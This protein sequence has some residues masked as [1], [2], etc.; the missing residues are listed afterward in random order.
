MSTLTTTTTETN[1]DGL[2]KLVF[3][4]GPCR[5]K[6]LLIEQDRI[7]FGRDDEN[8]VAI[9]HDI[10]SSRH[11]ILSRQLPAGSDS[12]ADARP[13]FRLR[14]LESKNGTFVNGERVEESVELVDG[15]VIWLCRNG[16]EVEFTFGAPELPSLIATST[17]T[18]HRTGSIGSAVRELLPRRKDRRLVSAS[19]VREFV[20][21]TLEESSRRQRRT[22]VIVG[23]VVASVL[24]FGFVLLAALLIGVGAGGGGGSAPATASI[25]L[26][27]PS[28]RPNMHIE[29]DVH[30]IFSSLFHS[31]REDGIGEIRVQNRGKETVADLHLWVDLTGK[32]KRL[33]AEAMRFDLPALS[34]SQEWKA[35]LRPVLTGETVTDRSLDATIVA[36]LEVAGDEIVSVDR[37]VMIHDYHAFS[38]E[39]PERVT[40]FVDSN[41]AAV[42][43]FADAAWAHQPESPGRG[44]P[45]VNVTR[46]VT[47]LTALASQ[48][49]SYKPDAETPVSVSKEWKARDRVN[50]PGETLLHG[51]G[52]CDDL[53]VLCC[54]LL[55]TAGVPSAVVVGE[56]HVLLMLDTGLPAPGESSEEGGRAA[57]FSRHSFVEHAGRIWLPIEATEL[58]RRDGTFS[59]AWGAAWSRIE[60]IDAGRMSVVEVREGWKKYKPLHPAPSDDVL[61]QIRDPS[62][63]RLSGLEKRIEAALETVRGHGR[64]NL[65]RGLQALEDEYEGA[66]LAQARAYL[67]ADG[68]LYR[69][70]VEVLE[71]E[72]FG[73]DVPRRAEDVRVQAQ[74][75]WK[76]EVPFDS[77]V[78]LGDLSLD[79]TLASSDNVELDRAVAFLDI[80]I[81]GFPDDLPEKAEM[82][83]RLGLIHLVRGRLRLYERWKDEAIARNSDLES[84]I[85]A[86]FASTGTVASAGDSPRVEAFLHAGIRR[87]RIGRSR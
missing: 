73:E 16:Q 39:R 85:T 42:R 19:G 48:G 34:P 57:L 54:S 7:S 51:T 60:A 68:G 20:A 2:P 84:R 40:V 82:M 45:P 83:L 37:A 27:A 63:W 22:V 87:L 18:Y 24:V 23:G 86:I 3:R 46:A 49:V 17:A 4:S 15:D 77:A 55:E 38:W 71:S 70:A 78:L 79:V 65:D 47:L 62:T 5:G 28:A 35:T 13:V 26:V 72:L 14:D 1:D 56:D 76:G 66:E 61:R 31:Y 25:G 11:A 21:G 75:R 10:V 81:S 64:D 50:F 59:S 32:G 36:R 53:V 74:R 80:A 43:A 33:L 44:F 67:Y 12:D 29:V 6:V 52:D 9:D 30:P 69:D 58:A 41:D 8:D